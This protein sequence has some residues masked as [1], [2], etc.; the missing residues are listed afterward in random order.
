MSK[1]LLLYCI[2]PALALPQQNALPDEGNEYKEKL[3]P[4][5]D[6]AEEWPNPNEL[7]NLLGLTDVKRSDFKSKRRKK[8]EKLQAFYDPPLKR[9]ASQLR[10]GKRANWASKVRFG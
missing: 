2:L 10:F 5:V 8:I 6:H 4:D 1:E 7:S 9:W 3:W